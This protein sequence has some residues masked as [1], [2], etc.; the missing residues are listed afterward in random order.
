MSTA[1]ELRD[2]IKT[3][4]TLATEHETDNAD[5]RARCFVACLSGSLAYLGEAEL[6][7]IVWALI[8]DSD[9]PAVPVYSAPA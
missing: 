9:A 1:A 3:A 2:A 8:S 4:V 5:R 7:Q 6:Q